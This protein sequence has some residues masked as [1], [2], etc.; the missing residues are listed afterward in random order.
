MKIIKN[1]F[2]VVLNLVAEL[3]TGIY[4]RKPDFYDK[5]AVSRTKTGY[6]AFVALAAMTSIGIVS[7][8]C[9]RI[10]A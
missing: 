5:H 6:G 1:F 2:L 4:R 9:V 7:W 10:Y 3:W 8:L